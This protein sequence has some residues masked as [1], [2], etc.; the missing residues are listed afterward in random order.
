MTLR[1]S[2]GTLNAISPLLPLPP[3]IS[4]LFPDVL[5]P[6]AMVTLLLYRERDHP[7][8]YFLKEQIEEALTRSPSVTVEAHAA[9]VRVLKAD[10]GEGEFPVEAIGFQGKVW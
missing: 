9:Q 6:A 3:K 7:V 5:I 8:I 1:S 4:V 2:E 10:D